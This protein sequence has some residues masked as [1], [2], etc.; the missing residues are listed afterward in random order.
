MRLDSARSLKLELRAAILEGLLAPDLPSP[1]EAEARPLVIGVSPISPRRFGL[2]VR[3]QESG[4]A[5]GR[6]LDILTDRARGEIDIRFIGSVRKHGAGPRDRVRPLA[7]GCS[8]GHIRVTAGT[9]GGFVRA[10]DGRESILSNNHVLA[11]EN[12]GAINDP[13]IQP[14]AADGGDP[15]RDVVA[16]LS[17]FVPL[18][19]DGSNAVDAAVAALDEGIGYDP[20]WD[21]GR[22][23][24]VAE[25]GP[26]A[27]EAV[28]K[29]G[30]TTGR[31]EGRIT[32]FELD[33]VLVQYDTGTLR[34]DD[35]IEIEGTSGAFSLPGDSGSLIV[36]SPGLLARGLLFAGSE[37]GGP[38]GAGLTYA[39][40]IG[41]VLRRL[42]ASLLR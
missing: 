42:E 22:L 23:R 2:S 34:F 12:R 21:G 26:E 7:M 10:A 29:L 17:G 19:G 32:A 40:R 13:V 38:D 31:T 41:E 25:A 18:R 9:L 5:R 33:D 15:T 3:I 20:G 8:I 16:R 6:H 4:L 11:D 24:G 28:E 14:A 36:T 37:R 35:A 27:Y 1:F 39:N 30:R